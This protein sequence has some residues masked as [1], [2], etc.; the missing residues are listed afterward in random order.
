MFILFNYSFGFNLFY[1][2]DF[3]HTCTES[4][5]NYYLLFEFET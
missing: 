1:M 4:M 5:F 3:R 2:K